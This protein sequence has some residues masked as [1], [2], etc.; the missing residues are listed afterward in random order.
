MDPTVACVT[1]RPGSRWAP[2]GVVRPGRT[3]A[4]PC[5]PVMQTEVAQHQSRQSRLGVDG[6]DV[7]AAR[8][9]NVAFDRQT[10]VLCH[11]HQFASTLVPTIL[12]RLAEV[13]LEPDASDQ[14]AVV[15][16]VKGVP[17]DV[18]QFLQHLRI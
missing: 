15:N 9:C 12:S 5:T 4:R 11:G 13:H 6:A 8:R 7:R 10:E 17:V 1:A 2:S 16:V 14:N 18:Q 3:A